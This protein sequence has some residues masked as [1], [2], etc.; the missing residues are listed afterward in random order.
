MKD[1]RDSLIRGRRHGGTAKNRPAKFGVGDAFQRAEQAGA[2]NVLFPSMM[3]PAQAGQL[4]LKAVQNN[5]LY[6][7]THGE[8]RLA[9]EARHAGL[10]AAMPDKVD[11][12]LMAM[13]QGQ[14]RR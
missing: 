14:P 6:I 2:T 8:W 13:L 9:A 3:E 11:P 7:I 5:E 10:I 4:V 1:L 12:A